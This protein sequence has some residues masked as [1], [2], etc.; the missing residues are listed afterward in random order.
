MKKML[1]LA[2][3][4]SVVT[5]ARATDERVFALTAAGD[6]DAAL[7]AD[8]RTQLEQMSGAVV[9]AAEPLAL[10]ADLSMDEIGR[11]AAQTMQATDFGIIV[12]ANV[13]ADAPQGVCLPDE[14]FGVINVTKLA[15]NATA[16]QLTRRVMQNALRVESMLV[17]M[18][19]C[20]S[21]L[22]TLTSY[23]TAEDLDHMSGNYCPPCQDRFTRLAGE[24]G[25]RLLTAEP[26]P[27]A[28]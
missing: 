26:A 11:A 9:R 20:P 18:S 14:H 12:L 22:C 16:G 21:P 10:A 25:L 17:G 6:V 7:V 15:V 8:V 23:E 13:G 1:A 27:A 28:E 19:V 24:L 2:V 5:L 4:L 3:L